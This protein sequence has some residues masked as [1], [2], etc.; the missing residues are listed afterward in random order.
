MCIRDRFGSALLV[1]VGLGF[2]RCR[3]HFFGIQDSNSYKEAVLRTVNLRE[4]ADTFAAVTGQLAEAIY[5]LSCI[6]E[7]CLEK[8]AQRSHIES[9]TKQLHSKFL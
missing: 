2:G 3:W 8:P 5:G 6:P 7:H 4:E 1:S 9:L